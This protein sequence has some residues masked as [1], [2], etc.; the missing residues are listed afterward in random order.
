MLLDPSNHIVNYPNHQPGK[1]VSQVISRSC[2]P[3][4][5]FSNSSAYLMHLLKI[6]L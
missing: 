5:L 1:H 4:L 2:H 6:L 3:T